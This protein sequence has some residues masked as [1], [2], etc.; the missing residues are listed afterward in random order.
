MSG[1]DVQRKLNEMGIQIPAIFITGYGEIPMTVQAM[2]SG[3]MEFLTKQPDETR[4]ER[5]F[6]IEGTLCEINRARARGHVPYC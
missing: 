6:R 5:N 1:L 3:A 4:A 2:K